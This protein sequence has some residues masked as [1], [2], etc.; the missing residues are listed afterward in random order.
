MI[1]ML[2]VYFVNKL[3]GLMDGIVYLFY[4]LLE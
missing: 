3:E 1:Y 4:M 2:L